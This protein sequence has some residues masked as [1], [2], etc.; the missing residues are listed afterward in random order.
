MRGVGAAS[1]AGIDHLCA[2]V[3][4]GGNPTGVQRYCRIFEQFCCRDQIIVLPRGEVVDG[5][6]AAFVK[7]QKFNGVKSLEFVGEVVYGCFAQGIAAAQDAFEIGAVDWPGIQRGVIAT[8]VNGPEQ[9]TLAFFPGGTR[10]H[11]FCAGCSQRSCR[12]IGFE[13]LHSR[14]EFCG[15]VG[16]I[17]VGRDDCFVGKVGQ[18][19]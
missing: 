16:E 12:G 7:E 11:P 18:D 5:F 19:R 4:T 1:R 2:E 17:F 3:F 6:A 14:E 9:K 8:K 15:D 10:G 13:I